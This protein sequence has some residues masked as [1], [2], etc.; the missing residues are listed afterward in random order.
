WEGAAEA[1]RAV[2]AS[3]PHD[4][5]ALRSAAALA[6]RAGRREAAV[7]MLDRAERLAPLDWRTSIARARI[8]APDEALGHWRSAFAQGA[9]PRFLDEAWRALPIGLVWV[10]ALAEAPGYRQVAL[11]RMLERKGEHEAALLAWERARML[12][13]RGPPP[14]GHVAALLRA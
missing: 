6:A 2:R 13:G 12:D 9:P 1:A 4:P 3:H 7:E 8:A 5:V 14:G 11:A 10:D